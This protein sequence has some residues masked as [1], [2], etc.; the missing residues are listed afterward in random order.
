MK[1]NIYPPLKPIPMEQPD[2]FLIKE[3]ERDLEILDFII[4]LEN[5]GIYYC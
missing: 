2:E 5:E 1:P 3:C 4:N